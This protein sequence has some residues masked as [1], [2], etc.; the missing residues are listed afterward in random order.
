MCLFAKQNQQE[1]PG[2]NSDPSFV[3]ANSIVRKIWGSSD[4]V[5][6]IFAGAAA[7]F[8]LNKSVD[9]LYFTGKLPNDPLER[10][11]STVDY[12]R[13]IIFAKED[14][15]LAAIDSINAIHK[16]VETKRGRR[17]PEQSYKDVLYMLID[18][19]IRAYELLK[20][21]LS[22]GEKEDVYRVFYRMGCRMG[23][24]EMPASYAAWVP[25][26]SMDLREQL[27]YSKYTGHLFQQYRMHLGSLRFSIMLQVQALLLPPI[28]KELIGIKE[29]KLFSLVLRAYKVATKMHIGNL[30][31]RW[32]LP[33]EYKQRIMRLDVA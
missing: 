1:V 17:I 28:V 20:R 8:A 15:A 2:N 33:P 7:E 29:Y 24:G 13:H 22:A 21:K 3:R 18:Y 10:M 12:A 19:S 4:V 23:I 32:L 14:A 31:K 16:G 6:F 25:E 30:C 11:F 26:R 5:L 27:V 9:W